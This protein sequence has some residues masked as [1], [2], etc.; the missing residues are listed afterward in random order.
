MD[1]DKNQWL[2]IAEFNANK[3]NGGFPALKKYLSKLRKRGN[4][5][6]CAILGNGGVEER[7][8]V[9]VYGKNDPE[10]VLLHGELERLVGVAKSFEVRDENGKVFIRKYR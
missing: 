6:S 3:L 7:Y 10:M 2:L 1:E 8:R 9:F 5:T 4:Q